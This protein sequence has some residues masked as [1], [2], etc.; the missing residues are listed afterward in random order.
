M[1]K[2]AIWNKKCLIF[3][4][5]N[6]RSYFI[7]YFNQ[8][9]R[10]LSKLNKK[11]QKILHR[12]WSFLQLI[13][14]QLFSMVMIQLS[15][16]RRYFSHFI[17]WRNLFNFLLLFLWHFCHQ[18]SLYEN[19]RPWDYKSN[20]LIRMILMNTEDETHMNVENLAWRL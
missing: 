20:N 19:T 10:K 1:I 13:Y 17:V 7:I 18:N 6:K 12:I 9:I 4:V 15:I 2:N 11:M 14:W 5:F 16:F 8:S 3:L